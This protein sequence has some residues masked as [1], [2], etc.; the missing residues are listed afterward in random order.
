VLAVCGRFSIGERQKLETKKKMGASSSSTG[1]PQLAAQHEA[2]GRIGN[3]GVRHPR[4]VTVTKPSELARRL[5]FGKIVSAEV[6]ALLKEKY[7][8]TFTD[9]LPLALEHF[10]TM[11]VAAEALQTSLDLVL[12]GVDDTFDYTLLKKDTSAFLLDYVSSRCNEFAKRR[13][14]T[15]TV[16]GRA[17][18]ETVRGR[19]ATETVRGES[20]G[21]AT[22]WLEDIERSITIG[23]YEMSAILRL[24]K[25][26]YEDVTALEKNSGKITFRHKKP[27]FMLAYFPTNPKLQSSRLLKSRTPSRSS[28][29]RRSTSIVASLPKEKNTTNTSAHKSDGWSYT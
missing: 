27:L 28:K 12:K 10:G 15:E 13:A 19:A 8:V 5:Q 29:S 18:T 26:I 1:A 3:D 23:L 20:K 24:D 9:E 25:S 4:D 7:N 16:R 2:V 14:A 21:V 17:A 22:T 6:G 11:V